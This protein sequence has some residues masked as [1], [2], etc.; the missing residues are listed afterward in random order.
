MYCLTDCR[1]QRVFG[2]IRLKLKLLLENYFLQ[3][4]INIEE[5]SSEESLICWAVCFHVAK[6]TD[7]SLIDLKSKVAEMRPT[8]LHFDPR[9]WRES[10]FFL[11]KKE[12]SKELN[13]RSTSVTPGSRS[14][15][16]GSATIIVL[17]QSKLN[18]SDHLDVSLFDNSVS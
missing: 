1:H 15:F 4:Q 6:Q 7:F 11:K 3:I 5:M 2:R 8:L 13:L 18:C 16:I 14:G 17:E 9:N 10:T 12:S